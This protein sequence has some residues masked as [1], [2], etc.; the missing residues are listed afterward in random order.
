MSDRLG[1]RKL[2]IIVSY[3]IKLFLIA[4]LK[5]VK[6]NEFSNIEAHQPE[7][8]YNTYFCIIFF[9]QKIKYQFE[10]CPQTKLINSVVV[11][12]TLFDNTQA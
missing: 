12:T 4:F 11:L 7:R 9:K 6:L 8:D 10:R 5:A 3:V 2:F 1:T